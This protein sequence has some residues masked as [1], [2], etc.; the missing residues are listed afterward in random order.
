MPL[1]ISV[2]ECEK[3]W[4]LSRK[5]T[6]L[7]RSNRHETAINRSQSAIYGYN[8]RSTERIRLNFW[9]GSG[10]WCRFGF[11]SSTVKNFGFWVVKW[12]HYLHETTINRRQSAMYGYNSRFTKRIRLKFCPGSDPWC[13]FGLVSL[14]VKNFGFWV[15]KWHHYLHETA[16][17]LHQCAM[18]GWL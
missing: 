11:E 13:R 12:H 8:S 3:I 15:G 6:S 9:P 5:M 1:G 4:V 17:N 10:M 2:I 14:T 16:I 18:Y 7:S